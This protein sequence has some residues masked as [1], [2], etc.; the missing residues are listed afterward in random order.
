MHTR[1]WQSSIARHAALIRDMPINE[2]DRQAV[3]TI[4]QPIWL[5]TQEPARRTRGRGEEIWDYAKVHGW[6]TGENPFRWKGNLQHILPRRQK[7]EQRHFAAM[8]YRTLPA[9][10]SDLRKEKT[11]ARLVLELLIL[12]AARSAEVREAQWPEIDF[13]TA[14]WTIPGTRMKAGIT[15][16]A[17]LS[18]RCL[19]ILKIMQARQIDGSDYIFPSTKRGRP[20]SYRPLYALLPQGATLHGLRSAFRDWCGNETNFPREVAEQALAHSAGSAVELAYR[21]SDALERRRTLM[22]AWAQYCASKPADNV[23]QIG[24]RKG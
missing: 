5:T 23:V 10:M 9:F 15:H 19:E 16:R 24:S 2:V 7:I 14:V 3:L 17:P 18:S 11:P 6:V 4:L 1:Q 13:D 20:I 12:T 8:D 22:E 21:R